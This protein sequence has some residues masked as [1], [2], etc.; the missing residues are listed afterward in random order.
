MLNGKLLNE[1][2][3]HSGT[4]I[5]E[6]P[7]LGYAVLRL[8]SAPGY[9]TVGVASATESSAAIRGWIVVPDQ[10][11]E[12]SVDQALCVMQYPADGSP[13]FVAENKA[14]IS[15]DGPRVLFRNRLKRGSAGSPCFDATLNLIAV[16][17]R[18]QSS[19]R[20]AVLEQITTEGTLLRYVLEDLDRNGQLALLY[21]RPA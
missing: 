16:T 8:P 10:A 20:L 21:Q 19:R 17:Q 18:S 1:G 3:L 11:P 12:V 2:S 9:T 13:E 5:M 14:V 15:V 7:I 4:P 6:N